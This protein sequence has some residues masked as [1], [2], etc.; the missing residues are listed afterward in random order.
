MR[1]LKLLAFRLGS[2]L[3]AS[4]LCTV[5]LCPTAFAHFGADD[6]HA[7]GGLGT[8]VM[9]GAVAAIVFVLYLAY[10]DRAEEVAANRD[11]RRRS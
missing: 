7:G 10:R 4:F 6:G 1:T 8:P 3:T 2:F 5:L 11:G 9:L